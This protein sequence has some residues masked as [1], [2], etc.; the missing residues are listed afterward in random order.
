M[1]AAFAKQACSSLGLRASGFGVL[2]ASLR[3]AASRGYAKGECSG[4]GVSDRAPGGRP[5]R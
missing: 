3:A 1:L 2:D 5:P 4:T